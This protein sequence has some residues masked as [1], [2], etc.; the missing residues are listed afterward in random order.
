[1]FAE[2]A[3]YWTTFCDMAIYCDKLETLI[4]DLGVKVVAP[5]H[6]LPILDIPLTMPKVRDGLI[7][8]GG[9]RAA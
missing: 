6:G 8:A 1:V 5:T 9:A 7:S 4:D 3:H 2:L